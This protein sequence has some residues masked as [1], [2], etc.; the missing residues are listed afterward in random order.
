MYFLII[1]L[2]Y[3][4]SAY[5]TSGIKQ[6]ALVHQQHPPASQLLCHLLASFLLVLNEI[7]LGLL[8]M[9]LRAPGYAGYRRLCLYSLGMQW[10]L[11]STL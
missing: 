6:N 11:P 9:A 3:I 5:R 8:C 10:T 2:E 7:P 1:I 4:P